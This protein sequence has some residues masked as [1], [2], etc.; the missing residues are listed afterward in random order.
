MLHQRRLPT[1]A[2]PVAAAFGVLLLGGS[3]MPSSLAADDAALRKAVTFYAS[4]D[5]KAE[6][7]FGQGDLRLWTR[8][9]DLSEKDKKVVRLGYDEE[10]IQIAGDRGVSG[11]AI[12]FRGR[13]NDNA[14]IFFPAAGKLAVRKGGWG[15]AVSL[16]VKAEEAKIPEAGPWDP[17]LLVEKAWNDGAVWCDFA[18]GAA[19]RDF[20]I[21]LFPAVSGGKT[22]PTLELGEKI[23]LRVKAPPLEPNAWHHIAQAWG[24][25]DT[26]NADAWSACYLDGKLVGKVEGRDGTMAWDL[27]RVRFHIGS[28]L[29]GLIDEVALFNRPLTEEEVA[30]LYEEPGLF[31]TRL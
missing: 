10:N 6:G 31:L 8:A 28:G 20:R 19:P 29:V 2:G 3:L 30:R 15:G 13:S 11:G 17:F 14:F 7:D 4:F 18:P 23:W 21:G 16:W 1:A 5:A 12:E 22:P 25:F 27:E 24:N 26:G 9:D